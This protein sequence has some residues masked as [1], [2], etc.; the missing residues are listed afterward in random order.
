[1]EQLVSYLIRENKKIATAESCTGGLLA[2]RL[3]DISG[4]SSV[5]EMGVVSYSNRIKTELL[6]VSKE[7]LDSVGAVSEEVAKEMS[8]GVCK[9]ADADIGVGIT[10]IAGPTGGSPEKPIGTVWISFYLKSS[11]EN[12]AFLLNLN[13]TRTDIRNKTCDIVTERLKELLGVK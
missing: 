6:G 4:V 10:G 1:M 13:G 2:S 7:L 12:P 8:K 9:R 5:F 11:G 3:T